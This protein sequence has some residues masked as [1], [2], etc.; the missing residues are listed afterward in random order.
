MCLKIIFMFV[1]G[2][3]C[4][5]FFNLEKKKY[6]C[7]TPKCTSDSIIILADSRSVRK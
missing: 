5:I 2:L 4:V 3:N 7:S 1:A 6:N